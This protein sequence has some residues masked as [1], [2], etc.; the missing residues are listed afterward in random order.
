MKRAWPKNNFSPQSWVR[1]FFLVKLETLYY[2]L[3]KKSDPPHGVLGHGKNALYY[4]AT[5]LDQD[6]TLPEIDNAVKGFLNNKSPGS[7]GLTAEFYKYFWGEIREILH[8]VFE[9]STKA[10]SLS[11]SQRTGIITLLPKQGKDTKYLKNWRPITLLNVDYK[12]YTHVIKNRLKNVIPFIISKHQTGFQKG[13]S[14]TDNLIL[15]YLVLE[16]YE[17][18]PHGE[19]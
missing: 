5:Q 1:N 10:G 17:R 18:N 14:T 19:G 15:M 6:I 11:P 4:L 12:I 13:K 2:Q 16:Y 8:K 9:E 3:V 7:D